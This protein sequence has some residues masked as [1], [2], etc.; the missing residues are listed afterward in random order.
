MA[1]RGPAS[2]WNQPTTVGSASGGCS[3]GRHGPS[4]MRVGSGGSTTGA[5]SRGGSKLLEIGGRALTPRAHG[6]RRG[7][8]TRRRT[9]RRGDAA[10]APRRRRS[11]TRPRRRRR[12]LATATKFIHDG[13]CSFF[14]RDAQ[15]DAEPP[16]QRAAAAPR[17]ATTPMST[18]QRASSTAPAVSA[19]ISTNARSPAAG[20]RDGAQ[21]P[22]PDARSQLPSLA[23]VP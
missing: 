22:E 20:Q 5:S 14:L 17:Q 12:Q 21:R 6:A 19:V 13:G 16:A 11:R 10:R 9:S 3:P 2:G 15:E 7:R 1:R 8:S 4:G 18:R 23:H